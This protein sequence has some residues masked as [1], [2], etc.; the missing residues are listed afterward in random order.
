MAKKSIVRDLQGNIIN[1]LDEDGG[2]WIIR[3]RQVVN[4]ERY[5]EMLRK[6]ADKKL[7][8]QAILN[9][10]VDEQAPDRTV[11]PSKVDALEKKVEGMETKLDAILQALS[12]K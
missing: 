5:D 2:G 7:A 11:P 6:E 10:K 8:A 1:L 9:Q 4:Q 3:N 12:K